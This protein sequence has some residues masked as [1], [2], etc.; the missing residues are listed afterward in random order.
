VLTGKYRPGQAL[1]AGSRAADDKG[2][3]MIKRFMADDVLT[4]VQALRPIAT[5]LDLSMAQLAVAWVLQNDNVATAIIGASRP[6]QVAENVAASGV[7]I[8]PDLMKR[9]DDVLDGVVERD[10]A[11]TAERSPRRRHA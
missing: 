2:A 5:E 1:P 9:I 7:T 3:Q 11:L 10:P 6:E 4:R 8:P